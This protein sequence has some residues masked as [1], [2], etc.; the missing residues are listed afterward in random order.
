MCTRIA[1]LASRRGVKGQQTYRQ[2]GKVGII[3]ASNVSRH[4]YRMVNWQSDSFW[5]NNS[6]SMNDSK[7]SHLW[8]NN[9]GALPCM[10][11]GTTTR[12][13]IKRAITLTDSARIQEGC[14]T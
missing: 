11:N 13:L 1:Q 7:G 12:L 5:R 3:A 2:T 9:G 14:S 8:G 10:H 4:H 6:S